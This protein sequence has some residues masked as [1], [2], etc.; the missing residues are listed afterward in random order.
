MIIF[1]C[2]NIITCINIFIIASVI[3]HNVFQ[4]N[5]SVDAV[6]VALHWPT[7][8]QTF[9]SNWVSYVVDRTKLKVHKIITLHLRQP[10]QTTSPTPSVT[11]H[12]KSCDESFIASTIYFHGAIQNQFPIFCRRTG[13]SPVPKSSL[14]AVEVLIK[15]LVEVPSYFFYYFVL[16]YNL[17]RRRRVQQH[18]GCE[19]ENDVRNQ[20]ERRGVPWSGTAQPSI[21]NEYWK[22]KICNFAQ[23]DVI[24][25]PLKYSL[26]TLSLF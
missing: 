6:H 24:I 26:G 2:I 3:H 9:I 8:Q 18:W 12:W 20:H 14:A 10:D 15:Y 19:C 22:H 21:V 16:T 17:G 5:F 1:T 25:G 11:P 23:I 4:I 7:V 13:L